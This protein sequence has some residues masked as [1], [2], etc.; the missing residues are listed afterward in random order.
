MVYAYRNRALVGYDI[1]LIAFETKKKRDAVCKAT[2]FG[3]ISAKEASKADEKILKA[4]RKYPDSVFAEGGRVR[5]V[6]LFYLK[7]G[8]FAYFD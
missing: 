8:S 3:A 2:D 5:S 6:A 4:A 1:E 7:D